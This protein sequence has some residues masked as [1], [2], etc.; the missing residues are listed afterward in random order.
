MLS[1]AAASVTCTASAATA[2]VRAV[3][4]AVFKGFGYLLEN[5]EGVLAAVDLGISASAINAH[6]NIGV[7]AGIAKAVEGYGVVGIGAAASVT[8]AA[9][10]AV[11]VE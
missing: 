6:G 4:A 2:A 11:S 9:I 3:C 10:T 1:T 7:A 8:C 5:F